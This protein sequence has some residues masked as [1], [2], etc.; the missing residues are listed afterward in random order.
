MTNETRYPPRDQPRRHDAPPDSSLAEHPAASRQALYHIIGLGF[1]NAPANTVP[2]SLAQ[3]HKQ[4]T[5]PLIDIEEYCY[6]VV[7]PVTKETITHYRKLIKDPLLKELWL[8]A[9]SKELH[10]LAQG[11]TGITKG[12]N[13][14]F[15]L[16]HAD[17]CKIPQDR[18]VTY[19]RIVID[20]QPQKEDPNR[21][22]ITVGGNLI[23]YPSELTTHT[24]DMVSSKILWNSVI[25][26]KDA[27]FAGADIKNMYLETPLD[28]Y[29]YMK[30]PIALFPADIIKY[31][32]L[33]DKV[34][35]GYVYMEIRKGMYGLPQAGVL[36]NKLLKERL[37]RHGYFE[38]PHTPGL[39]KHVSRPV[40]F[41][42]CVDDFG[43]KYIG[44]E[45]L[46]HLYDA[47][48][49]ETYEI[50][51]DLEGDLYCGI[52]LKWNYTKRYVDLAMVK[53]VMKQM[54][55]YGHV[56]PL[57]PQHCPYSPNPIKYG[58]DNQAPS[59][60]DDS[61][62]LDAAGKKRVQQIVGSFLYYA[63]AVDPT[64]LMALSEISS[65]QSAPTEN[66]MKRVN[67]FLDYM[68]THPDAIIRYRAS[69]M[70]L[71]VHSDASYLSAPK[72]RSRA[73][74]YFFLGSL[75]RDGDP[76]KLNGAIHVT[77]TILKLVAA[78]AAEAELGALF[79]NAQEAKVIRLVL[80]ELGHPQ[81]PTPIHIDNTTTVGIV[82]NT[83]K[84]QR[85]RSMEMRY[86]WL[87]DGATQQYF[88]FYYQPGLENLG[89]YPSKHHTADIHQHVRPYYVHMDNSP[90]L[91]PR[92]MKP[93]TRRGCAEI[94]GDPYSKKSP[95]PSI[96]PIGPPSRLAISPKDTSYRVLGQSRIHHRH[97]AP[98]NPTR[99]LAQ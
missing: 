61:P 70:I 24:A 40:W 1:T 26:T 99:I 97:I 78:S 57:K 33:M 25:S 31:Y 65:Q 56:A 93:S 27:R 8:K 10:R 51:E 68:W 69:D 79:L 11:C 71:N 54:T 21:V 90:T 17:I 94:L 91:L 3:Y 59:P 96:A 80:A 60:L 48:R 73:G 29:E 55:K 12:T 49:T 18:T 34:L 19:A 6:G 95:L 98:N 47:L 92:A 13:T 62:L 75:P 45:H 14:I 37:A 86:F 9:M 44:R 84:R 72:A 89:D 82:N 53:Y 88:K 22:C 46:Q 66:T 16:S 28:R 42:L 77:C 58:K 67:Q 43:I 5:G 15:Y 35:D 20:H 52:A 85:S 64:I 38:Q 81:P 76:I 39:W 23:D 4:Y 30:M 7:H 50:V 41:N 2:T 87:L 32:K 74:G 63:R 83:I 36:A